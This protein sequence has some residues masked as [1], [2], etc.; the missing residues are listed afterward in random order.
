M[1]FLVGHNPIGSCS[2]VCEALTEASPSVFTGQYEGYAD[3]PTIENK[4]T[5]VSASESDFFEHLSK[6][7]HSVLFHAS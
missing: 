6:A 2:H 1:L 7:S 5:N 3:D 4:D